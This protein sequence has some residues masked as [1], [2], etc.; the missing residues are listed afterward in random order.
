MRVTDNVRRV[1]IVDILRGFAL[2]GILFINITAFYA[3]GGPPGFGFQGSTFDHLIIYALILF[4]ESKF[5]TLFSFLFGVGFS[6]QLSRSSQSEKAFVWRFVR[7]LAALA[8]F[9]IA[10]IVLLWEGDILLLYALLGFI[11]LPFRN[12]SPRKLLKW[13]LGL[14]IV[15]LAL[16]ALVLAAI[17][18]ARLIPSTGDQLRQGDAEILAQVTQSRASAVESLAGGTYVGIMMDRVVSYR[19]T[20]FLLLSR[21]PSVLAMFLLG[22]WAGQSGILQDSDDHLP[23]LRGV[24]FCGLLLGLLSGLL[25]IIGYA[26]LPAISALV[27]L[28]FNQALAGPLLSSGYAATLILLAERPHWQRVFKPLASVGRMSLTNYLMQ[29]FFCAVIFSGPGFGL[30]GKVTPGA[31][32]L[33]ASIIITAQVLCSRLW[34]HHFRY[35]PAEWLWRSFTY[36]APQPM[37][38]PIKG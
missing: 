9:G 34:L 12:A 18:V 19:A 29:S 25:V 32:V 3:P 23:L 27:I 22:M 7:R 20:F 6:I 11:L 37:R 4:V 24:R 17:E 38:Q 30:A 10:H 5:F 35:G 28:F 33:I 1:E 26:W 21:A 2:S 31:G 16:F 13:V 15:P 8:L 14:L 36:L